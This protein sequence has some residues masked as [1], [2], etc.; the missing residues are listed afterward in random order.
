MI[1]KIL[2][3]FCLLFTIV[4]RG[5]PTCPTVSTT[6]NGTLDASTD[7]YESE[8]D[9]SVYECS[10]TYND[11]T[12][13]NTYCLVI[14]NTNSLF[15]L[16][17]QSDTTDY[18]WYPTWLQYINDAAGNREANPSCAL[19]NSNAAPITTGFLP[20]GYNAT[21]KFQLT[22]R[23]NIAA[24]YCTVTGADC[25]SDLGDDLNALAFNIAGVACN[26]NFNGEPFWGIADV[27]IQWK[28]YEYEQC[29]VT[30]DATYQ[31]AKGGGGGGSSQQNS[32][33]QKY[34]ESCFHLQ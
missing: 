11:V 14:G 2:L 30:Q 8:S 7:T 33:A 13:P 16:Q 32:A 25:I 4:V 19:L 18:K 24:T 28:H 6:Y 1:H 20:Q 9:L 3:L 15:Y 26:D 21:T 17:Y 29:W 5:D 12:A 34:G 31:G 22:S 23:C 27:L 10:C